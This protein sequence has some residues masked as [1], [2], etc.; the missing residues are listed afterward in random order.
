MLFAAVAI[1][2]AGHAFAQT[3]PDATAGVEVELNKLEAVN[4]ACRAYLVTQNLTDDRFDAF[5]LDVVMFDNDG[6]VARRLAV[7]I[8]PMAP[9]K[10][11]LKVFDIPNLAC[12]DIGQLLLNDVLECRDSNGSRDDCLSLVSVS[13]RGN[14]PFI[15]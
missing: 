8:G 3:Q 5:Q 11:S 10:T 13:Q 1:A 4:G 9:Q 2:V 7:Q 6:I 12:G 14:T 15:K